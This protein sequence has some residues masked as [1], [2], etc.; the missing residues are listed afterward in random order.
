MQT[1]PPLTGAQRANLKALAARSDSEI[2]TS[3]V[4]IL[5]DAE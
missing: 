1:L 2:D 3:D 4:P 5:T